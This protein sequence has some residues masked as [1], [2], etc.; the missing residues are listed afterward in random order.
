MLEY[1]ISRLPVL[2]DDS[3]PGIITE[4]DIFRMVIRHE[5]REKESAD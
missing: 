5:W 4:S 1:K 2:N 3:Q